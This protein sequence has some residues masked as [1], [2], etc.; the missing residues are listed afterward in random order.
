MQGSAT[1]LAAMLAEAEAALHSAVTERAAAM[2]MVVLATLDRA[3]APD[4]RG[5]ILRGFDSAARVLSVHTDARSAK[6]AQLRA[7]PRVALHAWDA[8]RRLQIRL[9][10]HARL[11]AGDAVALAAWAALPAGSRQ[12]YRVRPCPGTA[13]ADPAAAYRDALPD[14][15][16]LVNFVVVAI[17]YDGLETLRLTEAGQL[18]ARFDWSPDGVAAR[19]LVP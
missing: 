6:L 14:A 9:H 11:H 4:L 5:V 17:A 15:A 7:Q 1:T 3:G 8:A 18:R 12:L 10:G 16:A 19:W 2:R 13:L